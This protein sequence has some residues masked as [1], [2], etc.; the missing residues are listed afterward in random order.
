MPHRGEDERTNVESPNLKAEL[1]SCLEET[2]GFVTIPKAHLHT[3]ATLATAR[4]KAVARGS[5]RHSQRGVGTAPHRR[6]EAPVEMGDVRGARAASSPRYARARSSGTRAPP[7]ARRVSALLRSRDDGGVRR[8]QIYRSISL[9]IAES[10]AD[11]PPRLPPR[12]QLDAR[13]PPELRWISALCSSAYFQPCERHEPAGGKEK[14]KG[15]LTN[16][17]ARDTGETLCPSCVGG[18]DVVQVRLRF[19]RDFADRDYA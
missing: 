3:R 11:P 6:E 10:D 9:G 19:R 4:E 7:T 5:A 1:R 16:F 14:E 17:F 8:A 13:L 15:E 18:R 12:P 2:R